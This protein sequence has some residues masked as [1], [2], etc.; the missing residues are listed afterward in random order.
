MVAQ[1]ELGQ[2]QCT[3][4]AARERKLGVNRMLEAGHV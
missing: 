2:V 3:Q 1:S 4:V